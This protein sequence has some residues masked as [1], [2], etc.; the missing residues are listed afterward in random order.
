MSAFGR[1]RQMDLC[2]FEDNVVSRVSSRTVRATQ[3][4]HV[5]RNKRAGEGWRERERGEEKRKGK[6]ETHE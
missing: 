2:E 6:E 4:N 3:R 5:M 1:Q